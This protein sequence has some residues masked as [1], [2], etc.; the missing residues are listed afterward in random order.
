MKSLL[1]SILSLVS[2][3]SVYAQTGTYKKLMEE[4]GSMEIDAFLTEL[5]NYQIENSE[6]SNVYFQLGMLE[7]D[8]FS[9]LDPVVERIASRQYIYNAKTNF[10]LAKN[11]LDEKDIARNPQWYNTP[12]IKDKDSLIS[13]GIKT[14]EDN[15]ENSLR[16]SQAYEELVENH[17][18]AVAS[19][20]NARQGFIEINTS[21]DNLRQL[22]LGADDSLKLAVK[23]VGDA[24]DSSVVYLNKYREVYQELPYK[25]K[26]KV[27]VNLNT[28]DHFRMNGITPTN[29]LADEIELWDYKEWSDRFTRLLE[30]EVDGLHQEIES[31]YGYFQETTD[32]MLFGDECL[33]ANLDQQ[34]FQRI[35]N[36]INKYDSKSVL[37]DIFYYL[38]AKL[39]FGNQLVYEINCNEIVG[40]P[41]E[42]FMSRKGRIYQN[43]FQ[44]FLVSDS[45]LSAVPNSQER[46]AS[47]QWFFDGAMAEL[48]GSDGFANEQIEENAKAFKTEMQKLDYFKNIQSFQVDSINQCYQVDE[49]LLVSD[50]SGAENIVCVIKSLPL[51][52]DFHLLTAMEEGNHKL[53]FA[54]P[55]DTD[56]EILW[57]K[58]TYKNAAISFFKVVSD[59]AFVIGGVSGKAWA[60]I[61]KLNGA[62]QKP[63]VLK[64][65]DSIVDVRLNEL[66]GVL[67]LVQKKEGGVIVSK[68][69]FAGKVTS[70]TASDFEGTY[71]SLFTQEQNTWIC[72]YTEGENGS[73]LKANIVE[74][75]TGTLV[76]EKSYSFTNELLNPYLIK[77]DN[78]SITLVSRNKSSESEHIYAILNYEGEI[79]HEKIF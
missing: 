77:N 16:Y 14:I 67:T 43:L 46:E 45:L 79:T 25:N 36:L 78:E 51:S 15:Y 8:R 31:A 39:E 42:D 2:T 4:K 20:L 54:S 1:F 59:S 70:T 60:Q 30:S 49:T 62:E 71:L 76:D 29:F 48:N 58:P 55:D 53:L 24:F 56:Y 38:T 64:T 69:N 33:Q 17:D 22:F 10:G 19:Y 35:I 73:I 13:V 7:F 3:F 28:I 63:I 37:I 75:S 5:R 21:V 12:D 34:K 68:A 72:S 27:N 50:T 26:R 41:S 47:F 61:I 9:S 23:Q 6:Y 18:K 65:G 57:S 74:S 40:A 44:S 66:Q 32:L 52:D 11:Y